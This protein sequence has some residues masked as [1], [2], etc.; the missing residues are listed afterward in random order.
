M[1]ARAA[2]QASSARPAAVS[3]GDGLHVL[4]RPGGIAQGLAQLGHDLRQGVVGDGDIRPQSLEERLTRDE[5][6]RPGGQEREQ[7]ERPG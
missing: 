3:A 1:A 7:V 4:R 6:R 5:L 2:P